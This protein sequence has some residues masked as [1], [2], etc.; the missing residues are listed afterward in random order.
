MQITK[1]S[2]IHETTANGAALNIPAMLCKYSSLAF[3]RVVDNKQYEVKRDMYHIVEDCATFLRA[4]NENAR[5][6]KAKQQAYNEQRKEADFK[7]AF[8]QCVLQ[9]QDAI[10]REKAIQQG[11]TYTLNQED[12]LKSFNSDELSAYCDLQNIRAR[13]YRQQNL[14]AHHVMTGDSIR[15]SRHQYEDAIDQ[16]NQHQDIKAQADILKTLNTTSVK[17]LVGKYQRDAAK[18]ERVISTMS[19]K[20]KIID[21]DQKDT[22][23]IEIYN[24]I[25]DHEFKDDKLFE[26]MRA[27]IQDVQHKKI[28]VPIAI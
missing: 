18:I 6:I 5:I 22:S 26:E 23:A 19:S 13:V 16:I 14:L 17:K 10:L 27:G 24:E 7:M 12:M 11:H 20:N 1:Y 3:Y 9:K 28:K 15:A 21:D 4:E 25:S 2:N 8:M